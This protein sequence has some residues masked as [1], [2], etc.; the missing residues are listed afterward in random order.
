MM[1]TGE[2]A[3][4]PR[5]ARRGGVMGRLALFFLALIL[6]LGGMELAKGG[7]FVAKHEGDTLHLADFALRMAAGERPSLDFATPLGPLS[8]APIAAFLAA[9]WGFGH[10]LILAQ[11]ALACLLLP[12]TLRV[13]ASRFAPA[14]H[15]AM[16][17]ALFGFAVL[18]FV[19]ALVAGGT[20]TSVSI[21]MHYNR[22]CWAMGYLLVALALLRPEPGQRR[23][24]LDGLLIGVLAGVMVL[25]KLTFAVA[26]ALPVLAG[27]AL[28]RAGA[29]TLFALLGFVVTLGAATLWL[30]GGYWLAYLGDL[31]QVA[32]S[33]ARAAP[34]GTLGQVL[35]APAYLLATA[36]PVLAVVALRKSGQMNEGLLLLLLLPAVIY[37]TY[38]N[39]GN[40]PQWL[41]LVALL[42]LLWRPA[43]GGPRHAG[44]EARALLTGMAVALMALGTPSWVNL[45]WSPFR[46]LVLPAAQMVAVGP[47]GGETEGEPALDDLWVIPGRMLKMEARTPY[48]PAGFALPELP[49]TPEADEAAGG[50]AAAPAPETALL[51]E[52][53]PECSLSNGLLT[54]L[55]LTSADLVA[56][57]YG[58]RRIFNT[59]LVQPYPLLGPFPRLRGGAPW[60]YAGTPGLAA[61]ELV[62]VPLCPL[63]PE[64][65]HDGLAA[66]AATGR[67]LTEIRRTALYIMLEIS[68]R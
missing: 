42:L 1:T 33:S 7:L 37:I 3:D 48:R 27:L 61:A 31:L 36:L 43:A 47:A 17:A 4:V 40:D 63:S 67:Q 50:D 12:I 25:T 20:E 14:R 28:R 16:P 54:M 41:L 34:S 24:L 9:G 45:V 10:A 58:G 55:R 21:S 6:V 44:I 13:V 19:L 38:Q 8:A 2:L 18:V 51:G 32:Q 5:A 57:G 39:Y 62:L 65:R 60:Y 56:A 15:G 46:H 68:A 26:L 59:D 49:D 29:E 64:A 35:T 23:V 30:G 52:T 22:W 66:I 11:L 53:L